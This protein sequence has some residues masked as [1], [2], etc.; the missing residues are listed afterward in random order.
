MTTHY[1]CDWY[2]HSRFWCDFADSNIRAILMTAA[3]TLYLVKDDIL[4]RRPTLWAWQNGRDAIKLIV[5]M[6]A[7]YSLAFH[8]VL[9]NLHACTLLWWPHPFPYSNTFKG[10]PGSHSKSVSCCS[11]Q[12]FLLSVSLALLHLYVASTPQYL[13]LA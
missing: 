1:I 11:L 12:A 10:S 13:K 6:P 7:S 2:F 8:T 9:W 3:V 5:H 4:H